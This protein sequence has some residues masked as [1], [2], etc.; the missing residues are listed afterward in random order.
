MFNNR[1]MDFLVPKTRNIVLLD[2]LITAAPHVPLAKNMTY[3]PFVRKRR[4]HKSLVG[5]MMYSKIWKK[6]PGKLMN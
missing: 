3:T 5:T 1:H 6:S 4:G 2:I